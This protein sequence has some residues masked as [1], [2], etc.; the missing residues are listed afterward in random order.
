MTALKALKSKLANGDTVFGTSITLTD[1]VVS[2]V[3]AAAGF[4]FVWIDME[5][6][7]LASKDVLVH[8][9][10]A[11]S[12]GLASFVRVPTG[13]VEA[14]KPIL[15]MG[16]D[17][18]I[19]PNLRSIKEVKA[20]IDLCRYPP[21]GRRG[22]GPIRASGYGAYGTTEYIAQ[23]EDSFMLMFQVEQVGLMPDLAEV[24]RLAKVDGL[25]VGPM[26]LS[27][28]VEK[29][30]Q[31]RDPEVL[32]MMDEIA[33]TAAAA[34]VPLGVSFGYNQADAADWVRRGAR[35]VSMGLDVDFLKQ[36]AASTLADARRVLESG[37][38]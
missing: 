8:V 3:I 28:S 10:A 29:L 21:V 38:G 5:H 22:F 36:A 35:F 2:E 23:A 7:A 16:T 31:V 17:G 27:G 19:V 30:G 33:A 12:V 25:I 26:D 14:L 4:D 37:R 11:R 32:G 15:D 24:A 6:T 9:I 18:I 34:G 20:T 1:P 13:S